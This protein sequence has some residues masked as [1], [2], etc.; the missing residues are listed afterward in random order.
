MLEVL[1]DKPHIVHARPSSQAKRRAPPADQDAPKRPVIVTARKPRKLIGGNWEA[2]LRP[3]KAAH[4]PVKAG[5]AA[6][7]L[8]QE[9]VNRVSK[10]RAG[11][12]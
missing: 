8:W 1:T 11:A 3:S 4:D 7:Q 10:G 9:M 12:T 6:D 5:R 2:V